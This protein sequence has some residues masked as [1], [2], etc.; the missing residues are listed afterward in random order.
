MRWLA[1]WRQLWSW[2]ACAALAGLLLQR[3]VLDV[4]LP[5]FCDTTYIWEGYEEAPIG[6]K[7]RYRLIR[8]KDGDTGRQAGGVPWLRRD[9]W[10]KI[11]M[12]ARYRA[13]GQYCYRRPPALPA[14]PHP[15]PPGCFSPA[16]PAAHTQLQARRV[17]PILFIHGHLGT[18]QQMRSAASET[19]RE[20]SRRLAAD[21]SWPLWLQWYGA[22]FNSEASA[23]D[24]RLLVS[25]IWVVLRAA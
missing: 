9:V 16:R 18:H 12:D 24:P 2:L 11:G 14:A 22:D 13:A 23:L 7:Q 17:V 5:R 1:P 6:G 10:L 4:R 21:A 20:L 25:H 19:G 15:P 3:L 8:F